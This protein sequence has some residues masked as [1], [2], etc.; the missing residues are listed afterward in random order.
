MYFSV[1][2]SCS[3]FATDANGGRAA[4]YAVIAADETPSLVMLARMPSRYAWSAAAAPLTM[5]R[6]SASVNF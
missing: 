2:I 5:S 1:M 4:R 3:G 6:A